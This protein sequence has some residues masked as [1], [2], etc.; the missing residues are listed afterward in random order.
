MPQAAGSLTLDDQTDAVAFLSDPASHPPGAGPV[1]TMRTH[2]S[3]IFLVGDRVLK[4]K[5]AVGLPYADF[6]TPEL[7]LAACRKEVELNSPTAPG[8]YLGVRRITREAGG[9]LAF[10]GAGELVDAVVEMKRFE[11]SALFDR[12]AQAGALTPALMTRTARMIAR[13]HRGAPVCAMRSK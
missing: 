1:E 13:L 10:D 8:L 3:L 7:R 11:Q 9:G 4:M 5:R 12:M 2:I 6:S